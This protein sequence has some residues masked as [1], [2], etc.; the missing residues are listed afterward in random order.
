MRK[1]NEFYEQHGE[2]DDPATRLRHMV[3]TLRGSAGQQGLTP[4]LVVQFSEELEDV[5]NQIEGT[6]AHTAQPGM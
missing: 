2:R 5:A 6:G 3:M 4:E 1:F